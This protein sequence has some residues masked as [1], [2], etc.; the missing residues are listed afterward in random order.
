MSYSDL[1]YGSPLVNNIVSQHFEARRF[2]NGENHVCKSEE[3]LTFQ[4]PDIYS[5]SPVDCN[6]KISP[7]DVSVV[8]EVTG[9]WVLTALFAKLGLQ[10][11]NSI[12]TL[13]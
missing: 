6:G 11:N 5:R 2:S 9:D 1:Y 8:K 13:F 10:R 4:T 7:V 12:S 3:L